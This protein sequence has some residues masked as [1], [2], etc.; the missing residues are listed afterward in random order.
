VND[1]T[2]L[3]LTFNEEPNLRRT[4][5]RLDWAGQIVIVDSFST[6]QTPDIARDF[7]KVRMVQRTF[8][9][10]TSQWNFGVGQITTPWVLSLDADYVLPKEFA[11]E[12]ENLRPDEG[13]SACYARFRYCVFGRPLRATLYPPRAVLFRKDRCHYV[14]DGHTQ[15]L[16]INGKTL[17]LRNVIDHDD[18]KPFAHWLRAQDSY[19]MQEA[20][21]LTATPG[22]QLNFADRVRRRIVF[23]PALVF[24]HTL[25]GQGLVLDGWRGWYYVLQR[26][27][28]ELILSLRLME[29]KLGTRKPTR[30]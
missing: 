23:A 26:T 30:S 21:H 22:T 13:L 28:A 16:Q 14:Q 18:R 20:E 19:A 11:A 2:P 17:S 12:L 27:L 9:D 5:E 4:L 1:V 7:P 15:R 24:C 6:D 8:D 25:I 3:I 29:K 10:H